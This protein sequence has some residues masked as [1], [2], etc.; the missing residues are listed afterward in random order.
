MIQSEMHIEYEGA[1]GERQTGKTTRALKDCQAVA[2]AA[3]YIAPHVEMTATAHHLLGE[4]PRFV[5]S[6]PLSVRV[7]TRGMVPDLVVVDCY[8][9]LKPGVLVEIEDHCRM[10]R[11]KTLRLIHSGIVPGPKQPRAGRAQIR[12]KTH[13]D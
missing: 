13:G 7:R 11:A 5:L 8:D 10:I 9:I 4:T 2:P 6:T 1:P 3:I 12:K